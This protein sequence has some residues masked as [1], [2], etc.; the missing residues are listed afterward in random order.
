MVDDR[1]YKV[2]MYN[3]ELRQWQ[4]GEPRRGHDLGALAFPVEA[5]GFRLLRVNRQRGRRAKGKQ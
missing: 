2:E 3:S 4:R 5:G 1:A